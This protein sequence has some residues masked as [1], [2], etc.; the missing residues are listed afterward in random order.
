MRRREFI[1]ATLV[2][3]IAR[4]QQRPGQQAASVPVRKPKAVVKLF[5]SPDGHPNGLETTKEGVPV[6]SFYSATRRLE[7]LSSGILPHGP[8]ECTG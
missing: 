8:A 6:A 5:K 3:G 4:A 7:R 2:V 1:A